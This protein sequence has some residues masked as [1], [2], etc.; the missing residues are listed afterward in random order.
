MGGIKEGDFI[1]EI[2]S[3][4]AKWMTQKQAIDLIKKSGNS[5]DL[6]VITP[7]TKSYVKVCLLKNSEILKSYDIHILFY[8]KILW[9]DPMQLYQTL[10][11]HQKTQ[12]Q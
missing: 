12:A 9:S 3:L 8:S 11:F 5:L 6:K 4:D 2:N 10:E 1:V 7:M